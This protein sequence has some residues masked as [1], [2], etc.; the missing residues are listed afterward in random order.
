MALA[1]TQL[2]RSGARV[3]RL[4][5]GTL[6]FGPETSAEESW[7]IMD[8]SREAGINFFD[9]A[10]YYG[11]QAGYGATERIIGGWLAQ[12]GGRR[13]SIFLASKVYMRTGEGVN[14]GG[15]SA[16]H[17]VRACEASLRRL[18]TDYLDL[19]Q[20]HHIDRHTPWEEIWQAFDM[21]RRQGKIIYAGSSNFAGWHI[22]QAQEEARARGL[23]GII[24]EQSLYNLCYRTI[25]LEVMP[26]CRAYGVGLVAWGVLNRGFLASADRG[27][28][29][30]PKAS[31]RLEKEY[32]HFGAR[33]EG[34][35]A[36]CARAGHA[37]ADVATAWVLQQ[38]GVA[39]VIIGPRSLAQLEDSVR[40]ADVRLDEETMRGLEEIWPGPG[41]PAPG[42]YAW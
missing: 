18:R 30:G 16:Y 40:A 21:L 4:A 6:N 17:I 41:G 22:A 7:R 39:A 20:M 25:E 28:L 10:D 19:Y 32:A 2:G 42:A 13:E 1:Y 11:W 34:Y 3:S 23:L 29:R 5:L 26:A 35:R 31:E 27:K 33:L 37:P 12:G 15:L 8:A 24:S 9:T 38:P 36:V 14:D